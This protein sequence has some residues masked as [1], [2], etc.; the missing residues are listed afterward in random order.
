[1]LFSDTADKKLKKA[2]Q[3]YSIDFCENLPTDAEL[4]SVTF[5]KDFERKMNK[6]LS[7]QKKAYYYFINSVGKRVAIIFLA[8]LLCLSVTT[9][10]VKALREP[11]LK[12]IT[13]IFNTHTD[14]TIT[15][16][17]Y[18]WA[19]ELEKTQPQYIPEGFE[20]TIDEDYE[21]ACRIVYKNPQGISINYSQ[22]INGNSSVGVDTEGVEF[23]SVYINSLEGIMY[24]NKG[25]NQIIFGN[26]EYYFFLRGKVPMEEL[27]KMAESIPIN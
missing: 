17:T 23:E 24:K 9:F 21:E 22:Q 18:P 6:L 8:L 12:F 11:V 14:V 2:F 16:E 13:Q 26:A 27:I 20:I 10:S 3:L 1:M 7:Q 5:S 15:D 25:E 4:C 19:I